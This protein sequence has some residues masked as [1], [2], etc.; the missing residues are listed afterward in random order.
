MCRALGVMRMVDYTYM[1]TPPHVDELLTLNTTQRKH[2]TLPPKQRY[3]QRRRQQHPFR[4]AEPDLWMLLVKRTPA[5]VRQ[6]RELPV[7]KLHCCFGE[8]EQ[9]TGR[10]H[11]ALSAILCQRTAAR[12]FSTQ[13]CGIFALPNLE[14]KLHREQHLETCWN[15]LKV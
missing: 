14:F 6:L 3:L 12:Q 1:S 9:T 8:R 4:T 2:S 11:A 5:S 15:A 7:Y 13:A 10:F